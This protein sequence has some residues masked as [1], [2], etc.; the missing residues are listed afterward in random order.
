MIPI[1]LVKIIQGRW[2]RWTLAAFAAAAVSAAA[3][4]GL[5]P[6]VRAYRAAP[7]PARRAAIESYTAAHPAE[8]PLARL[9]LGV[10]A[11]EYKDYPAAI[12]SLTGLYP[13]YYLAASRVESASFDNLSAD[14][15]PV[16]TGT[17][18]P[19]AG[20]SWIV[21]ARAL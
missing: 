13:A 10:A 19:L 14:A 15:A 2:S 11:Y 8:E 4:F 20:K 7:N 12:A 1:C 9:A 5:A 3:P 21:E 18:S 16:H 6:L 17:P